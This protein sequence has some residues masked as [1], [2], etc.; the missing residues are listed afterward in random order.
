MTGHSV[1]VVLLHYAAVTDDDRREA[2]ELADLAHLVDPP[3]RRKAAEMSAA[4]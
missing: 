3:A 2:V 1:D 4:V